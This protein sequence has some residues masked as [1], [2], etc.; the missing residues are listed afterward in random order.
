MKITAIETKTLRAALK[1]PFQTALR[2]VEFLEDM[3]VLIHTNNGLTGYGEGAPTPV[4]TGETMGTMQAVIDYLKPFLIGRELEDFDALTNIVQH[5]ILK[6][7]TAKSALEIALYDLKAKSQNL[8]LYQMLGGEQREFETDITIS[9][10]ETEKMVSDSLD[11]IARGYNILKLKVGDG[12]QK[13]IERIEAIYQAVGKDIILRLDANQGWTAKESVEILTALESRGIKPEL[14]EQPVKADDV[15][16]LKYIKER[17]ETPLLADESVFTLNDARRLLDMKAVD[18]INIKLAKC[19]GI[20][21]ALKLA[22]IAAEYG[23]NCMLGCMLEGPI[24]VGAGV[25][26]ASAKA[27]II[28]M[29]DLDAVSLC[30]TNPVRG[31]VLFSE[32]NIRISDSIGLGVEY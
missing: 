18:L 31:G 24:S 19:G 2:R 27:N 26:V 12:V 16:G 14:V 13:D 29:L 11:A 23:V 5:R 15:E 4:I 22:D 8:P 25:H 17:V 6:N 7:T 9:L 10:G 3:I 20:S 21:T 30:N 1:T 32:S 28:T